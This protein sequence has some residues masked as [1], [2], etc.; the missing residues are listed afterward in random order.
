MNPVVEMRGG[1]GHA[2][3]V[4]QNGVVVCWG[5]G[6]D[7]QL[8]DGTTLSRSIPVAL[9]PDALGAARDLALGARHSCALLKDRSVWCWGANEAGQLG[10]GTTA[11]RTKP[12]AVRDSA[13]RPLNGIAAIAAGGAFSCAAAEGGTVMCWG[14]NSAGALGQG[15]TAAEPTTSA[16]AVIGL[17]N[18]ATLS[19]RDRHICALKSDKT[20]WCW[21]SN[22]QGELGDGSQD[23]RSTPTPVLLPAGQSIDAVAA[24]AAHTCAIGGGQLW[25]W[26]ANQLGELGDGSNRDRPLPTP[27]PLPRVTT[28]VAAGHHTCAGQDTGAAWCWGANQAGQLGEGTTS[29]FG[30]PVPV[31]GIEDAIDLSA[32]DSFSCARRHDG[33]IWCW[34]DDRLGQLGNGAPIERVR[35][36]G[37]VSHL[38]GVLS[39]SAGGAHTCARH[40]TSA[41]GPP[42]TVC[43][44]DN[45]AGQIGDGTR[46]DRATPVPL[47]LMLD[48]A[49]VVAGALHTCLRGTNGGVWCW[50]RGGAGQLGTPAL[51]DGIVPTNVSGLGEE[52]AGIAAGRDHTCALLKDRSV[53]CWG[54]NSEGQLGDGTTTSRSNPAV[55]AGQL[56]VVELA[57]GGAHAC[58]RHSD[59]TVS[60]WGRDSEGQL[61]DNGSVAAPLPVAVQNLTGASSIAAGG[62]HTCAVL[63]DR[64]VRC[65]GAGGLGQLGWGALQDHNI[66]SKVMNLS[67]VVEIAAGENHTCARTSADQQLD[68]AGS[69]FCWGDNRAAQL[70][71]GS[72]D[73]D[74]GFGPV[75]NAPPVV[76]GDAV[77]VSAGGAHSCALKRNGMVVCWG[78]DSAGQLGDAAVLQYP[79]AQPTQTLCP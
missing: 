22:E 11:P 73:P 59:G 49:Q 45:Q 75:P 69:V 68:A 2:C 20:V 70:G 36:D 35:P 33:T 78:S 38:E 14:D 58:A 53:W 21:G 13:G 76:S 4:R 47:K 46:L 71:N 55:V 60:C 30:V 5:A 39:V 24:G 18:V 26:G 44:G 9:A 7:G 63:A 79:T 25:C 3:E 16:Q 64:T 34:G 65:W 15:T 72:H 10:D 67:G 8:G 77:A 28:I 17:E 42:Q 37:D 29:N 31:T 32:G 48:A 52:A 40:Q 12:V 6:A 56:D 23:L 74:P 19:A 1:G 54:A 50:G 57:L 27:V 66:P 41:A 61:G 62:S 43:W 51:I